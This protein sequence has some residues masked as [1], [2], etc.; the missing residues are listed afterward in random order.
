MHVARESLSA[1]RKPR[2]R[3][4]AVR[5]WD[6]R[7]RWQRGEPQ[8]ASD[9]S[10]EKILRQ[11]E[12][13]RG[14]RGASTVARLWRRGRRDCEWHLS[15]KKKKKTDIMINPWSMINLP[16][17]HTSL[18]NDNARNNTYTTTRR[19]HWILKSLPSEKPVWFIVR[20]HPLS[21]TLPSQ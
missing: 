2:R 16:I 15:K 1:G 17:T 21:C 11:T 6:Q 4:R 18:E 10:L 20:L 8:L 3:F 19:R 7:R 13:V 12:N 5:S 9:S 14:R